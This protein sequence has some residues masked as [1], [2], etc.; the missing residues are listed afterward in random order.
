MS[1]APR[2]R[3]ALLTGG[4]AVLVLGLAH[5]ATAYDRANP[6][7]IHRESRPSGTRSAQGLYPDA[8]P[9]YHNGN[10]LVCSDCHIAH[11]SQSHP[12]NPAQLGMNEIV[13][14]VGAPSPNLIRAG[15]PLDL[16]LSCHDNQSFAPDVVGADVNGLV[17]RSA[18]H[19]GMPGMANPNGHD[20]GRGLPRSNGSYDFCN[21]CHFGDGSQAQV[22]C[23]DCH[24]AHG[25]GK[26]RNLQWASDPASTPDLGLFTNPGAVNLG[27]YEDAN[28][29]FGTMNS[30]SLREVSNICLDCH[31]VFSGEY[32]TDANGNGVHERHPTYDSERASPNNIAQGASK[33]STAPAHWTAGTGSGFGATPRVRPVT[34][35]AGTWGDGHIV[36]AARNGVFCLS[37]HRAHGSDQPFGLVFTASSG[38]NASGCDQC[39]LTA[40]V[41]SG[42]QP[43]SA[44]VK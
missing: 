43:V 3:I 27:R 21:R 42:P 30:Y 36:D 20:L 18:G 13:P 39:H 10:E 31:H 8:E 32:Y 4:F 2:L 38:T 23:I 24:N 37:C 1:A 14:Y 26:A 41:S 12:R 40:N 28:V 5:V 16:C 44:R 7:R 33:G 29:S 35:N 15:D 22:T 19:F 17:Q 11:A 25:N 6:P 34:S 9:R